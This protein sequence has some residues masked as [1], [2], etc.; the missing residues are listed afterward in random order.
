MLEGKIIV[1]TGG[2]RGIGAAV[3]RRAAELGAKVYINFR[4]SEER[5]IRVRDE[6]IS[7][8]GAAEVV[9]FDVA[10]E[11]EVAANLKEIIKKEGRVD[12]LV[13]NAG[14]TLNS[15]LPV[16]SGEKIEELL[17]INLMGTIFCTKYAVRGM[18]KEGGSIVNITSVVGEMGNP[19]QSVYA[20][21]KGG[22]IGFTKAMA[23]ELAPRNIRVNAVSPGYITT[24]MTDAL[25]EE[26]KSEILKLIPMG[27]FGTPEEVADLVV[28]LLSDMSR[29]ITGEVIRINGGLYT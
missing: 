7:K 10:D 25:P 21:S 29:Y 8:G 27:R 14:I 3:V 16:T 15:L 2:S 13:N 20:A 1:V 11:M 5:A 18:M 26:L 12:G 9:Q 6:I 23:R 24:E 4:K 28:F 19:G 22:I 17:R